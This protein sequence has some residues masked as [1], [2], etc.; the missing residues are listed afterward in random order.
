MTETPHGLFYS[1]HTCMYWLHTRAADGLIEVQSPV[2]RQFTLGD[3][4]AIWNQPLS[5][6]ASPDRRGW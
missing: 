1:T 4:F 3:F 2:P 6:T 5:A